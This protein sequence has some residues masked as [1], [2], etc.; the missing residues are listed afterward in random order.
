MGPTSANTDLRTSML[1][2]TLARIGVASNVKRAR[3]AAGSSGLTNCCT[4]PATTPVA[5]SPVCAQR[6]ATAAG[7]HSSSASTKPTHCDVTAVMPRLS[8][9]PAPVASC[10]SAVTRS[11]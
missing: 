2:S 7:V 3:V 10:R 9:A 4:R 1:P 6:L 11:A 8:A 5:G